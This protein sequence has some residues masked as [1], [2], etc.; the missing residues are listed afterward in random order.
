[1]INILALDIAHS[2]LTHPRGTN[3]KFIVNLYILNFY[4]KGWFIFTPFNY[5]CYLSSFKINFT[6]NYHPFFI[7]SIFQ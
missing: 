1:M 4:D 7:V 6:S 3:K 5:L 2:S